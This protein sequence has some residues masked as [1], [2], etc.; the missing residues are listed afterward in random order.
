MDSTS[1]TT[2]TNAFGTTHIVEPTSIHTHTIILLHGR[3]STG[4]EFAE[5]LFEASSDEEVSS[6]TCSRLTMAQQLPSWRWV[7]PS[8]P[9]AWSDVFEEWMP[10]WFDVRSLT[11][12]TSEQETQEQGLYESTRHVLGILEQEIEKLDRRSERVVLGGISQGGATALWTLFAH[13]SDTRERQGGIGD[14]TARKLGAFVAASTW[15]PFSQELEAHFQTPGATD[16]TSPRPENQRIQDPSHQFITTMLNLPPPQQQNH[17]RS[18][19][20][21]LLSATPIFLGHGTDDAYVDVELGRHGFRVLQS[22]G[23]KLTWREYVGAEQEGHWFKMPE[24]T[25]DIVQF[26]KENVE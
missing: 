25:D 24:E 6:P 3:G 13:Y 9:S 4:A 7:F 26:L 8:S 10:S 23:A 12:P 19:L 11:D 2:K 22:V 1:S 15:L 5:E 14:S 18:N 17:T 20:T 21:S 16:L